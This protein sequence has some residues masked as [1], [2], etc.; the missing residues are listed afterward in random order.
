MSDEQQIP[1]DH[2]WV[3]TDCEGKDVNIMAAGFN[4]LGEYVMF[5]ASDSRVVGVHWR[6]R[7]FI[8]LLGATGNA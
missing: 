5:F 8:P 1:E 2:A 3:I 4:V 7:K 6:P